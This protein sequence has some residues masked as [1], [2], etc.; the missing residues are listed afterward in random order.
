MNNKETEFT[1]ALDEKRSKDLASL[2]IK[3]AT[4]DATIEDS[5]TILCAMTVALVHVCGD[6][7]KSVV[8]EGGLEKM[9]L[10]Y[11]GL[12]DSVSGCHFSRYIDLNGVVEFGPVK[13]VY[14]E[15]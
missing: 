11:M 5:K 6:L 1:P 3:I 9:V 8:E 4:Q 12:L 2:L 13:E 14:F 10:S 7:R 15:N